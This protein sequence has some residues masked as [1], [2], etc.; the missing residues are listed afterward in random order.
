MSTNIIERAD[1][2][3]L[4]NNGRLLEVEDVLKM[5]PISRQMLYRLSTLKNADERIPS[6]KLGGRRL[7]KYDELMFW[8]DKHRYDR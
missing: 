3:D 1:L 5:W 4:L 6:Y 2:T 8:L 7:F